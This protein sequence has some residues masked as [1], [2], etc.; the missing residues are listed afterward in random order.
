METELEHEAPSAIDWGEFLT[1]YLYKESERSV[2]VQRFQH[3]INLCRAWGIAPGSQI[4]DIGCGQGISALV[5]ASL[6]AP[7]GLVTA[8]DTAPAGYGGPYTLV[9]AQAFIAA[10]TLGPRIRFHAIDAPTLLAST[11]P[12][13]PRFDYAVLCH[14]LWYFADGAT[15]S[16]LFEHLAQARIGRVC[17]A[18]YAG[19]P[20]RPTSSRTAQML[21][22]AS[23]TPRHRIQDWNVRVSLFPADFIRIASSRGWKVQRS[24]IM[25]APGR[26]E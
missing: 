1:C 23:R 19:T 7:S 15:I 26:A 9:D 17:L 25:K 3:R 4:L 18:E 11:T 8:I 10:S 20:R 12:P 21:L 6:S 24:G 5:L 13:P 16:N 14:S 2:V 22:V